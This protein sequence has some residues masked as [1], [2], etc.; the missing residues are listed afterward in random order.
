MSDPVT[1]TVAITT[2]VEIGLWITGLIVLWRVQFSAATRDRREEPAP[3]LPWNI[4]LVEF[5]QIAL[6][7][8]LGGWGA[9]VIV[10]SLRNYIPGA[11]ANSDLWMLIQSACLQ[12]G[13]LAGV[14]VSLAIPRSNMAAPVETPH[15][16]AC[17]HPFLAAV[18]TFLIALPIITL[19]GYAWKTGLQHLGYDTPDQEL[20]DI[21]RQADSPLKLGLLTV[22]AAVIAPF[23]EELVFRAGL[24]RYLRTRIP[25]WI[26]VAAPAA[27]FAAL[28][29]SAVAFVPLFA[30][31]VL[32]SLAY[33]RT[34][35]ISVTIIAHG[36]FNLHTIM[37]IIAGVTT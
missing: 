25:R 18:G 12:F 33:E 14:A 32:F 17:P 35:R 13:L 3:L 37:L 6:C 7:V 27:L 16:S 21:F 4:T 34:G 29:T 24:F 28:H 22:L 15:S 9:P 2:A 11:A 10:S 20:V 30:L 8:I 1:P 36:L 23:T 19:L 26:A 5:L 31:G